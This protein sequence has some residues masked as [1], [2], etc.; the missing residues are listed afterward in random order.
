MRDATH[1]LDGLLYHEPELRI[2]EHYTDTHGFTDHVF[3]LYH[4]LG[5]RFAARI[6]DLKDKNL[7]VP[8]HPKNYPT[9]AGF[10]GEKIN[11]KLILAQWPE[12][13]RLATSIKQG[14]VTAS[15]ML[16]KLASYPRQN[17][18]ALALREL[19]RIERTL[20]ALDWLLDPTLR[21]R[22]TAGLNKGEAKNSLARAVCFNRLGEIRDR[23]HEL[24]RRIESSVR[25]ANR[26]TEDAST[27]RMNVGWRPIR[28]VAARARAMGRR[29]WR[30]VRCSSPQTMPG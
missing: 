30:R 26:Y 6:R 20:F 19:G 11:T 3:A 16:R 9:L 23:T 17:G 12:I 15:L 2:E 25:G 18:L 10:L 14:T 28:W 5:F 22:V 1:V 7:Y 4:A 8:D 29:P 27:L 24:Q 21:Q 13:L